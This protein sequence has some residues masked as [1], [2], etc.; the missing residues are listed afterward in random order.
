VGDV[1]ERAELLA[2]ARALEA[3]AAAHDEGPAS[4]ALRIEAA[5]LRVQ[6]LGA[7]SY[8]VRVCS[9]CARVTGWTSGPGQCNSCLRRTKLA[10]EY[11]DPHG[12]FVVLGDNRPAAGA[13]SSGGFRR[14]LLSRSAR[15][16]L[17]DDAWLSQVDPGTTGPVDPEPGYT[18][19]RPHR[20]EIQAADRSGMIVRF[21]SVTHRFT[22]DEW[23]ELGTTTI[24][25]DELLVPLE[26]SAGLPPE[27]LVEA[28][29]DFQQDVDSVNRRRWSRRS[30]ERD[31]ALL[32]AESREI[33]LRTQQ[34]AADLLDEQL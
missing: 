15:K 23:V 8:P 29:L 16:R 9:T 21:R 19:E 10:A 12:G 31:A 11:A 6:A 2:K 28:W 13:E 18:V 26:H 27:Q 5:H 30:D 34:G 14:L 25:S 33:V 17:A 24:G 3:E 20:D 32:D 4:L 22:G 7:K 1:D